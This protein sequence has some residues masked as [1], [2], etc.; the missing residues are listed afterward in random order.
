MRKSFGRTFHQACLHTVDR[1]LALV[2]RV[3]KNQKRARRLCD[4]LLA[5]PPETV[6]AL[7]RDGRRTQYR[8]RAVVDEL[9]RRLRR[10]A[11]SD[12]GQAE[13]IGELAQQL[14]LGM[15]HSAEAIGGELGWHDVQARLW[16]HR[17]NVA[18]IRC[19]WKEAFRR[20]RRCYEHQPRGTGDPQLEAEILSLHASLLKDRRRYREALSCLQRAERRCRGVGADEA[21]GRVLL[22]RAVIYREMNC[23]VD[24]I[25]SQ[26]EA[27]K[28]LDEAA[29]AEVR[30]AAWCNLAG[31]LC[32]SGKPEKGQEVLAGCAELFRDIGPSSSVHLNRSWVR[33]MIARDLG[34]LAEAEGC[35]EHIREEYQRLEDPYNAAL[36][37]LDL[38]G[39]YCRQGRLE[40]LAG[41]IEATYEGL[42]SQELHPQAAQALELLAEAARRRQVALEA[43]T[44]AAESL[45]RFAACRRRLP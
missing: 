36:A 4:H 20:F 22:K 34:R 43:I 12:P 17:A 24:A 25:R 38:A 1:V 15:P 14:L 9:I 23:F 29:Q 16:A 44:A 41:I 39:L 31:F 8:N 37:G 19:D 2:P 21:R 45:R 33:G 10:A 32:E 27:C 30:A 40:D 11:F 5:Q 18:R 42:R 13:A 3:R 6:E 7:L 26:L 35:F 28:V